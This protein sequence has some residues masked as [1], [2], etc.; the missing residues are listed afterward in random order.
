[1]KAVAGVPGRFLLVMLAFL[2]SLSCQDNSSTGGY[3]QQKKI[4]LP[5]G[6]THEGWYFA[7]GDQVVIQGTVNGDAYVAGGM[8]DVD[9]TVDGDLYV[10]GGQINV[11]GTVTHNIFA[12]GGSIRLEGKVGRTVTACGGTIT[13]S[14]AAAIDGNLL[15][16]G[17]NIQI[18]GTVARN[19]KIASGD[20]G[21][22][23]TINGD[24]DY[25]GE[26]VSISPGA[27]VGGNL[28][29]YA[30]EKHSIDISEGTVRGRTEIHIDEG[31]GEPTI[32]GMTSSGFWFRI[33]WFF[34]LL[35]IGLVLVF[36]LP[37]QIVAVGA[38]ILHSPGKSALWGLLGFVAIPLAIVLTAVTLIGIPLAIFIMVIYGWLLYFSQLSIGVALGDRLMKLEAKAGWKLFLP[39]AV[40]LLIVQLLMLV[41]YVKILVIVACILFGLGA[42]LIVL[43]DSYR[44][45]RRG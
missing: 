17:G 7:A 8:V 25:A 9:G 39:V 5:A 41:P 11:G 20:L 6:Q 45:L 12:G 37:K 24:V 40:G 22:T 33:G 15:E 14:R 27:T 19:A 21:V 18:A 32:L 38:A 29:V 2:T 13:I 34:S 42:L 16:A 30:K 1:M 28:S 36:A 26:R 44:L 10:A 3:R 4:V 23:G 35:L 43:R 31:K